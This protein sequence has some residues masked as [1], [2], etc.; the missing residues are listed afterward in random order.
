MFGD[1]GGFFGEGVPGAIARREARA[2]VTYHREMF[3]RNSSL[4]VAGRRG[5]VDFQ[6]K[7]GVVIGFSTA[8]RPGQKP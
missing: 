3:G 4:Y 7:W 1:V 2:G 6:G 5:L 8:L